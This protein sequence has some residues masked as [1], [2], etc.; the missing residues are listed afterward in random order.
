MWLAPTSL[1]SPPSPQSQVQVTVR[2]EG[3]GAAV[4]I[5][6]RFFPKEMTSRRE[7][8]INDAGIGG[9][10]FPF[11]EDVLVVVRSRGWNRIG[12]QCG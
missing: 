10:D 11:V 4:V 2:S 8:G 9:R 1:A 3:A 12:G 6:L 7:V 5:A